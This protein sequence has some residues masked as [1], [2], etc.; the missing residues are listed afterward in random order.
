MLTKINFDRGCYL[1][2]FCLPVW[3]AECSFVKFANKFSESLLS[4]DSVNF[5]L[6]C[7]LLGAKRIA[8]INWTLV[9]TRHLWEGFT[10]LTTAC[11][12]PGERIWRESCA[13]SLRDW[14]VQKSCGIFMKGRIF[15][16]LGVVGEGVAGNGFSPLI[17]FHIM[18]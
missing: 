8:E 12:F 18:L 11:F 10:Q 16:L 14:F 3:I 15:L 1:A 4:T 9:K 17:L 2:P 7:L 6:I 5:S 13:L